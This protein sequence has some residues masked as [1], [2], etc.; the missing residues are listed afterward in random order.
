MN[1]P[2]AMQALRLSGARLCRAALPLHRE[3]GWLV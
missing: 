3:R 2:N 1:T